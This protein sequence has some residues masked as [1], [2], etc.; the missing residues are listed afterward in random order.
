MA[1][2]AS[3]RT[4]GHGR[5]AGRFPGEKN[6]IG[7]GTVLDGPTGLSGHGPSGISSTMA[8]SRKP[9]AKNGK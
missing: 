9:L 2:T 7:A 5:R 4:P 8:G 1:E 6:Y 3:G